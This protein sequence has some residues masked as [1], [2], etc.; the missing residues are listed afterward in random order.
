MSD[1]QPVSRTARRAGRSACR[2]RASPRQGQVTP[3]RRTLESRG[4]VA[5]AP[6]NS[7]SWTCP[8]PTF[9]RRRRR[10]RTHRRKDSR[11]F[12]R[13]GRGSRERVH[14]EA[15]TA[16]KRRHGRSW[17]APENRYAGDLRLYFRL[18]KW[19]TV[20][21]LTQITRQDGSCAVASAE[22]IP[23]HGG[24]AAC[25]LIGPLSANELRAPLRHGRPGAPGDRRLPYPD[26]PAGLPRA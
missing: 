17:S 14:N 11:G 7:A 19:R 5:L 26:L 4:E 25:A 22:V 24:S 23:P 3:N 16:E 8:L 10:S 1:H 13:H 20:G 12:S 15:N 18:D 9:C 2:A 6:G 21:P